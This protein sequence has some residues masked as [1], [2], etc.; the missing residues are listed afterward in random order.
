MEITSSE[1]KNK[2]DNG[3]KII[4]DFWAGFCRPCLAMKPKF[5]KMSEELYNENSDVKMY[6]FNVEENQEYSVEL[7]IRSIPTIKTFK[8]GVEVYSKSGIHTTMD[9]NNLI[10]S[11]KDG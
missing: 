3:E 7:G 1:L 10:N 9:L 4:V 11:L 8:N 6:T 2:I 5:D